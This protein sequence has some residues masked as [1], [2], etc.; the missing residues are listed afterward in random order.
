MPLRNRQLRMI[1]LTL[2]AVLLLPAGSE[3][4]ATSGVPEAAVSGSLELGG[5]VALADLVG[6]WVADFRRRYPL[7]EVT[8][9]DPGSQA[10]IA[11]LVNGS[12][13]AVLLGG[14]L[15][16]AARARF[17]QRYGYPPKLYPVASDG[18]A[19]Y[20][21]G[22]NPLRE[23]TLAQLDA[24]FSS[25]R[26]CGG[27]QA[28]EHWGQLGL[29]GRL[30]ALRIIPYGLDDSTGAWRVFRAVALCGGDFRPDFGALAGPAAVESA[31]ATRIGAIGFSSSAL[32]SAGIR[33]LAVAT[34]DGAAAVLP[35]RESIRSRRY[36]LSRTL[37]IAV[38][39]PPGAGLPRALGAFVDY[40]RSEAGQRVAARSGYVPLGGASARSGG[41]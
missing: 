12:E 14:P 39:L 3:G 37:S 30:E 17:E 25:T 33:A 16:E 20:V 29:G 5:S 38:N 23:I 18:V 36:P 40:V 41:R 11:A 2:V 27:K 1:L 7:I 28:I 19:V 8:V 10:G 35:D 4:A 21:N 9:A 15:D 22:L 32:R 24:I 26:R 6:A 34:A 31:V 13:D